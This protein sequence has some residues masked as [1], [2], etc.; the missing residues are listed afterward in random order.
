MATGY[1]YFPRRQV[2]EGLLPPRRRT[3]RRSLETLSFDAHGST[4]RSQAWSSPREAGVKLAGVEVTVNAHRPG[5]RTPTWVQTGDRVNTFRTVRDAGRPAGRCP[6]R[7]PVPTTVTPE[8]VCRRSGSQSMLIDRIDNVSRIAATHPARRAQ[9]LH[10][11]LSA[12]ATAPTRGSV[13]PSPPPAPR[14]GHGHRSAKDSG[15]GGHVVEFSR[16]RLHHAHHHL[17]LGGCRPGHRRTGQRAGTV[18]FRLPE[19]RVPHL[20]RRPRDR[21][22]SALFGNAVVPRPVNRFSVVISSTGT[23]ATRSPDLAG[24]RASM[25]FDTAPGWLTRG[26]RRCEPL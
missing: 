5:R 1:H 15:S 11:P 24:V 25:K 23:S 3:G 7:S 13:R 26:E 20:H 16:P 22:T 17:V 21:A 2:A 10:D 14:R 9:Q 4:H 6:G 19:R 18:Q 12:S 8:A